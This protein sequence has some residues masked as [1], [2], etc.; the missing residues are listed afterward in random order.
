MNA[1]MPLTD[2][3]SACDKIRE[4]TVTEEKI[5]S[6]ELSDKIESVYNSGISEGLK[7]GTFWD[8]FQNY[9]KRTSYTDAFFETAFE[10]IRP[11]YK[12][13]PKSGVSDC[14][15]VFFNSDRLKK[16]ESE[17]FDF[18]LLPLGTY[19]G[20][21]FYWTFGSCGALEEI[22]N[23]GLENQKYWQS[24]FVWCGNLRK[25]A[26]IRFRGDEYFDQT[27]HHCLSLEEVNFE[28][29][30][31]TDGLDLSYSPKL[32]RKSLE[33]ILNCLKDFKRETVL[34]EGYTF[35]ESTTETVCQGELNEG[36]TYKW[37]FYCNQYPGWLV[38]SSAEPP[39]EEENILFSVAGKVEI[40]GKEYVGFTAVSP[41]WVSWSGTY[42]YT[43]YSDNGSIK[44]RRSNA[45]TGDIIKLASVGFTETHTL[46]LG[47]ANLQKLTPEE[48]NT[49]GEKGWTLK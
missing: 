20:T 15:R 4:K 2:Y 36:N 29:T 34:T 37:S 39:V 38:D 19:S 35:G 46:T 7:E 43:V 14:A 33:S 13:V 48:I 41:A 49:A 47:D 27:F 32:S 6:G 44:V 23:I 16:L 10:Y 42:T 12:I 40:D 30:V 17:Y 11:K 1:V 26:R 3:V 9:G 8:I 22:E 45:V 24:T 5:R 28:G 31:G 25:I 21:G 18:S